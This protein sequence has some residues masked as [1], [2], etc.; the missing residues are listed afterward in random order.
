M[1]YPI[2]LEEL[3]FLLSPGGQE[4]LKTVSPGDLKDHNLFNTIS[5]L[6]KELKESQVS[7]I[8]E[9]IRLRERAREKFSRA[10][11]MY[12]L[13][14]A[15]EQSS[16]EEVSRHHGKRY[17]GYEKIGDLTCGIGGDL[18]SLGRICEQVIAVDTDPVRLKMAEA[19]IKAM[20][21]NGNFEFYC[22]DMRKKWEL[23]A[24]FIDPSRRKNGKRI[25]SLYDTEPSIKDIM[26]L[27]IKNMGIKI[28]P[29][30]NYNEIPPDCEVEFISH[31]GICKE[32]VLW[33]GDLKKAERR[34]TILPEG[35][36]IEYK[37]TEPVSIS[38][39]LKYIYEPDPAI[40]RAQMVEW[41]AWKLKAKKIDHDI[42]YLTGDR[43]V[44]T[45][46]ANVWEIKEV[47]P[48]NLKGIRRRLREL[49]IGRVIVK[50]RGSVIEPELFI[51][52]LKLDNTGDK[53]VLFLTRIN[54]THGAIICSEI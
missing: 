44:K 7:A 38:Q 48:F 39:P 16:S 10:H 47:L 34:A 54:G 5:K 50:K 11:E 2:S 20:E 36:E 24:V 45:P 42:A 6:R 3:E 37:K 9:T 30:V 51:K 49:N 14:D 33:F 21:L 26:K 23:D 40:I 52:Q 31:R 35:I 19:N 28:M 15:L 53:S 29:G 25:F 17:M 18:I 1:P 13:S 46:M 22:C 4:T 27:N 41:L 8:I 32:G 43:F 12:F